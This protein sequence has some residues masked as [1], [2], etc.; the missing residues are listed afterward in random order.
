MRTLEDAT[1]VREEQLT[2]QLRNA[3]R[4]KNLMIATLRQEGLLTTYQKNRTA[5]I[6]SMDIHAE[7]GQRPARAAGVSGSKESLS[8]MLANLQSLGAALLNDDDDNE[9]DE[10]PV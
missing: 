7:N 5:A 1:R 3:E 6:Q 4:D 2:Q 8:N 9:D 10:E